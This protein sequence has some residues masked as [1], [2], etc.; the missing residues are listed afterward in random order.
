M[1]KR[2]VH[3]CKLSQRRFLSPKAKLNAEEE[4]KRQDMSLLREKFADQVRL[5]LQE[6][7]EKISHDNQMAEASNTNSSKI[8][9]FLQS[10]SVK[11]YQ[12]QS[13]NPILDKINVMSNDQLKEF[14]F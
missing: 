5:R 8:N 3:W 1:E 2:K 13:H 12:K 9:K 7:A 11:K 14:G 10:E 6:R 4:L